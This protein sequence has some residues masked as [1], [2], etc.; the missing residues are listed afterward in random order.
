MLR[1]K[2]RPGGRMEVSLEVVVETATPRMPGR[3]K[4]DYSKKEKGGKKSTIYKKSYLNPRSKPD[5]AESGKSCMQKHRKQWNLATARQRKFIILAILQ[6]SE[7][8]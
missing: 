3:R 6:S 4:G 8:Q 7:D 2:L 5:G 1:L